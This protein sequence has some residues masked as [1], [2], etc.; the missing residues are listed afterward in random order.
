M[1]AELANASTMSLVGKEIVAY[2]NDSTG[3]FVLFFSVGVTCT[4]DRTAGTSVVAFNYGAQTLAFKAP[5]RLYGVLNNETY[6]REVS[7]NQNNLRFLACPA[8]W[9]SNTEFRCN[10]TVIMRAE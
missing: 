6:A 4:T 3:D 1:D 8:A 5:Y 9:T 2:K 7:R 10:G